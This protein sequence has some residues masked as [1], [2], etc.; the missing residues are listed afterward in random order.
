M[1]ESTPEDTISPSEVILS[2]FSN[3]YYLQE[4]LSDLNQITSKVY[5]F[6]QILQI[7]RNREEF[8]DNLQQYIK[9]KYVYDSKRNSSQVDSV[10]SEEDSLK[11][12]QKYQQIY[13]Y[14]IQSA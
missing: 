11:A 2:L 5:A 6:A 14:S 9:H 12:R 1:R 10:D 8:I 4:L 7:N 3:K 13:L